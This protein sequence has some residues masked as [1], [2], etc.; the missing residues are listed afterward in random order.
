MSCVIPFYSALE[1]H[2]LEITPDAGLSAVKL[3]VS[4]AFQWPLLAAPQVHF[5]VQGQL[6]D[7]KTALDVICHHSRAREGVRVFNPSFHERFVVFENKANGEKSV[8]K[9]ASYQSMEELTTLLSDAFHFPVSRR[10]HFFVRG[11]ALPTRSAAELLGPYEQEQELVQF[12]VGEEEH[13]GAAAGGRKR[14]TSSRRKR[15]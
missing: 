6:L 12:I 5:Y 2:L 7:E 9:V 4:D 11:R 1:R 8:V 15:R 10:V 13:G 3:M 14:E